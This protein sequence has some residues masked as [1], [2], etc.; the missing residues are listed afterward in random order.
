[1]LCVNLTVSSPESIV[2]KKFTTK[3]PMPV[4]VKTSLTSGILASTAATL[5]CVMPFVLLMLG[6]SGAWISYLVALEPYQPIFVTVALVALFFAYKGIFLN[7]NHCSEN[8][9]FCAKPHV[10]RI[11]KTAFYYP[12]RLWCSYL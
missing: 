3:L 2:K 12:L 11:Y 10:N 1:M 8:D 7:N 9:K 6:I 4:N 5:C